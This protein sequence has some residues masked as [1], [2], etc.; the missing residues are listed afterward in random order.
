MYRLNYSNFYSKYNERK[1]RGK[2]RWFFTMVFYME[3]RTI[4][5]RFK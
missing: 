2:V 3:K 1:G 5:M 4:M